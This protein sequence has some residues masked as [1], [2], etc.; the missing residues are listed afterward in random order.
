M[1]PKTIDQTFDQPKV[2]EMVLAIG[3][4]PV[5]RMI[6]FELIKL[7]ELMSVG[8]NLNQAQIDFISDELIIKYPTES[9]A[10]F[11]ICFR[12]GAIGSYGDIQ[13]MDGITIGQWMEKY[14]FEKYEILEDTLKKEKDNHYKIIIPE[15]SERDWLSEWQKAVKESEGF[16]SVPHLTDDEI[17]DEGQAEPKRKVYHYNE[18]EAQIALREAREKLWVWQELTVRERHP[19]WTEEEIK[20]RCDELKET[21]LYED[22]R[23]KHIL[24][25]EKIWRPKKNKS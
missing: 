7:A 16:K 2:S 21:T 25:I 22:S 14:L 11:K 3:E 8:G 18:S 19:D 20:F 12:K 23:P 9:I 6:Q 1:L 4:I 24:G 10:D 5:K 15:N 17:K 13:R